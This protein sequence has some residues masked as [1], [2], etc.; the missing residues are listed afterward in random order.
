MSSKAGKTKDKGPHAL[1]PK[2]RFPE[3]RDKPGWRQAPL[4]KLADRIT[5]RNVDESVTRV[6]TN[7]AEHGVLDQRDYFEKDIANSKNLAG[8][9]IV[10]QGDYVYNPRI[11]M[12]APVGPVSRN[13]VAKGVMSPLYTVFRFS[14]PDTDFYAYFFQT[15]CW[16]AYLRQVASTGARHDRMSITVGDFMLMPLPTPQPDEQRKI[17]D[18]LSSLD[19]LIA[20]EGRKLEAL[21]EY[22][23]GLMLQLLPRHGETSPR[24]RFPEFRDS[25]T[26]NTQTISCLL[27]KATE[28][29]EIEADRMYREIGIRSHGKGIFHKETTNAEAIGGKRVFWVVEG[30]LVLNIVFAWEQAVAT[31][32][33]AEVGMIASHRFPMYTPKKRRCD[34]SFLKYFFLTEAG[35]FLLGLASPGGAGRN[36]T[37]GQKE[38]ERLK[39]DVPQEVEEQTRIADCLS[40][41]DALIAAQLLELDGL[42]VHKRGLMQQLFPSPED[43]TR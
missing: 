4:E 32:S 23:D 27:E 7:S 31:T 24:L 15:K 13:N 38:F 10:D 29:V 26:W 22:R 9:Y 3:F 28:P 42:R 18:C 2:L 19:D 39:I 11:S 36:R 20:A 14:E 33:E 40:S 34:V 1:V 5:S 12:L 21:K 37:L 30:A 16:H 43:V 41:L 17:A 25:K 35:R 6:L 8:Y